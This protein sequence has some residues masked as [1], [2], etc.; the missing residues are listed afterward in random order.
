MGTLIGPVWGAILLTLLPELLRGFGDL[1]L[2]LYGAALTL[3]VLFM[4]GGL[5]QAAQVLRARFGLLPT[6]GDAG[7]RR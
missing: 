4:P 5:V 1:R 7:I 6:G 2:V 3:V